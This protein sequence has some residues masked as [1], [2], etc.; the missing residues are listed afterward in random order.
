M[1]QTIDSAPTDGTVVL[2]T[3]NIGYSAPTVASAVYDD[4]WW[5][6]QWESHDDPIDPTHWMPMPEGPK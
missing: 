1:W 4:G 5:L 2:V 6:D 3:G